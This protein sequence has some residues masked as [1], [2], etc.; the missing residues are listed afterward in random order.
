VRNFPREGTKASRG[1]GVYDT[2]FSVGRATI[3]EKCAAQ[4]TSKTLGP[5]RGRPCGPLTHNACTSPL[6]FPA[7]V[8]SQAT[9]CGRESFRIDAV[10]L[11]SGQPCPSPCKVHRQTTGCSTGGPPTAVV[12]KSVSFCGLP[13]APNKPTSSARRLVSGE[14]STPEPTSVQSSVSGVP[15]G[16]VRGMCRWPPRAL[17]LLVLE[18]TDGGLVVDQGHPSGPAAPRLPLTLLLSNKDA[19]P[20]QLA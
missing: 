18:R 14:E 17:S 2:E 19:A 7:S 4:V 13:L 5:P 15:G 8:R 20:S 16:A 12:L 9:G 11:H 10:V 1:V 3:Q 6:F